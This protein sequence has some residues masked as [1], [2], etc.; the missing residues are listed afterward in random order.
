MVETD[1][2]RPLYR[3]HCLIIS[4]ISSFYMVFLLRVLF[5]YVSFDYSITINCILM[6]FTTIKLDQGELLY[7]KFQLTSFLRVVKVRVTFYAYYEK[8]Y[9]KRINWKCHNFVNF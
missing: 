9:K 4:L 1:L 3:F 5:T 7:S 6:L 2:Q 8:C